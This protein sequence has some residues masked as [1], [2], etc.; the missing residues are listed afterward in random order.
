MLERITI[1]NFGLIDRLGIEFNG[2]LNIFTGETGAG[3]SILFDALRIVLGGRIHPTHPRDNLKPCI[4]EAVFD[5][6][7]NELRHL[8]LLRDFLLDEDCSLIIQR[9]YLPEGRNKI[10]IN[11]LSV[12]I[13]QLKEIGNYLVDFHGPHSHQMLFSPGS[14]LGMLDRL[15]NF[16]GLLQQYKNIYEEYE[17]FCAKLEE[18]QGLSSSRERELGLL[19]HQIKE[20]EQVPLE[21]AKCEQI[22][23][24][25][26][27]VNNAGK[28]HDCAGQL[29][30]LLDNDQNGINEIVRQAFVPMRALNQID[31]KTSSLMELLNQSQEINEQLLQELYVYADGLSFQPEDAEEINNQCDVYDDIRKKYG[32]SL[33]DARGFYSEAKEKHTLLSNLEHNDAELRRKIKKLKEK[34][35][36]VSQKITRLRVKSA[37]FL[38]KTI[39]KELCELG[40]ARVKFECRVEPGELNTTGCDKVS[41]YISPNEGEDL[42][43]L[44]EIVSSGEAARVMLALKK[45]L[46]KVDPVPVLIFDEIDAQIG[47]RLGT[48]T[49]R[50]FLE[51]SESR[52]VILITHLPQIASFAKFHFKV[53]KVV[54]T[55][56]TFTKVALLNKESRVKEIAKMMSGEKESR[57]AVKHANNMLA[58]AGK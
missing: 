51:L 8:P 34:L 42:M 11:G 56:R 10:K 38:K 43:P 55:G 15:V 3:K 20:L 2:S 23:Q 30:H 33:E 12:T 48:V 58:K 18:L 28:L 21:E 29:M 16:N 39:E 25:K 7:D 57:I 19:A 50:K 5:L 4:I 54:E 17:D 9:I 36:Q 26:I 49:G 37:E 52:Q 6:T 35:R 41:F 32:P 14:H 24:E 27:R 45:A 46:I 13:S 47:G 44:A 31:E 40:I 22:L 1:Q 53:S